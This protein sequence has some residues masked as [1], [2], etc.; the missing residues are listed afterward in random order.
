MPP[1]KVAAVT[2]EYRKW[3]HADVIL[4]NLLDG[5][6]DG[7]KPG[8]ELVALVTDQVPKGDTSRALAKKHGFAIYESVADALT[9]GGKTLAVHGVL[10][11]G[12]HGTYPTNDQGQTLYPRRRFFEDVCKVFEK[13]GKS[14][15]VFND[16]HLAATWDD[17]KW[18]YDR[19][20]KLFV[21]LMAGSSVPITWRKPNLV[22]PKDC[23]LTGAVQI[24][25]GPFEGYGFHALEGLQCM[26]E[27]RK[28]GE[29][30][31]RAVTCHPAKTM[32]EP[33]DNTPWA[34][35][36]LRAALDRVA[37]HAAGAVRELTAKSADAGTFEI[38][39]RD[40][41]RAFV[42]MPNGWIH[43][44]D[45]GGFVFA[46]LRKG[47]DTPD[48]CQFYLQQPDPFAHFAELTRAIDHLVAT[49]HAP[50]PVERTLVTT[51]VLD[52]AMRSRHE[53]GKRIETPHLAIAY[54]PTEW[55]PARGEIP[56]PQKK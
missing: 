15:P 31:V 56:K 9:L 19:A 46:G 21:P 32:W 16:K 13:T 40:G 22:L 18:M 25:Y 29:T 41:L 55:G 37:A 12:E 27:R 2:T 8:L 51:G 20:R 43:E 24:G 14:V 52:A 35:P 7:T 17:A 33:L 45:G 1:K 26:V 39:Y 47:A 54:S 6:P 10:S 44:G 49:G 30:G 42:V 36:V 48:A 23:E 4:R 3:S 11:I 53:K 50:Y 34:G 5:Y 28:G 38:E